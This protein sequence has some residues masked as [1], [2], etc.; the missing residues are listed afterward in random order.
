MPKTTN[1]T[2]AQAATRALLVRC[3]ESCARI[4]HPSPAEVNFRTAIS[5]RLAGQFGLIDNP[6]AEDAE[7]AKAALQERSALV[8]T[9]EASCKI[10]YP[11]QEDRDMRWLLMD[12]LGRIFG[13]KALRGVSLASSS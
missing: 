13:L 3:F 10:E 5:K 7:A 9:F 12:K 1:P 2:D 11:T 4:D 6:V 8:R